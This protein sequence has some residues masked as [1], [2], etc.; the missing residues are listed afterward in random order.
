MITRSSTRHLESSALTAVLPVLALVPVWVLALGVFWLP[1]HLVWPIPFWALVAG[2]AA[3]VVLFFLRPVQRL[4]LTR[5]LGARRPTAAERDILDAPWRRVA[6]AVGVQPSHYVVVVL[7]AEE[8]NAFACGGH[9]VVV[10]S[11][12]VDVLPERELAGVLAHELSHHLGLHTV[13]LTI[14]QWLSLP[15]LV[16]ARVGFWLEAVSSAATDTFVRDSAALTSIGRALSVVLFMLAW[17]F[18]LGLLI[19]NAIANAVGKGA[20]LQADRRVVQMGFG[21]ELAAALRRIISSGESLPSTWR[22][23]LA[24][25]HPPA[26]TRVAHIE[27][28]LRSARVAR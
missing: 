16:L 10:T 2:Y 4:V 3:G 1:L 8:L 13:A 6:Q 7:D 17:V 5:L 20:E 18:Q 21:R 19:S 22:E 24:A 23:R 26:R 11:Y 9:L 14:G 12:A 25:S 28:L 27:A 15:I